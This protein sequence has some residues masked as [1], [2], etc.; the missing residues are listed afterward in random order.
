MRHILS[1]RR[2]RDDPPRKT[3]PPKPEARSMKS[4]IDSLLRWVIIAIF[5]VLVAC[6]TWQ[7]LSRYVLG[8]PST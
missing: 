3:T 5:T 1:L 4:A 8:T 7:V 2:R 6:V